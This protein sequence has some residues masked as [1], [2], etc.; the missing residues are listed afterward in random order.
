MKIASRA[1]PEGLAVHMWP[2]GH[3]LSTTALGHRSFGGPKQV[4]PVSPLSEKRE[5]M[6]LLCV[7]PP[8]KSSFCCA[9]FGSAIAFDVQQ[10][11]QP[12]LL[13]SKEQMALRS[14]LAID[15]SFVKFRS[16]LC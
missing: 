4:W 3:G 11:V 16:S 6:P 12:F 14:F 5:S 10:K 13:S 1:T 15:S 9:G 7:V 8:Q 2:A